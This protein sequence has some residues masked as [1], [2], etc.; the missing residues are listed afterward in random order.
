MINLLKRKCPLCGE[1]SLNSITIMSAIS[2][3]CPNCKRLVR[4]HVVRYNIGILVAGL[5][6]ILTMLS[7][8]IDENIKWPIY[9]LIFL[10]FYLLHPLSI[11]VV[12]VNEKEGDASK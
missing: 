12:A 11:P 10:A 2:Y 1:E 4:L 3:K 5:L 9:F 6:L 8:A 7:E